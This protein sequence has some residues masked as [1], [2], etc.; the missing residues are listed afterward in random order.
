MLVGGAQYHGACWTQ[1]IGVGYTREV[2]DTL[3]QG[4]THLDLSPETQTQHPNL[5]P[6]PF[7]T[8]LQCHGPYPSTPK[9]KTPE[10]LTKTP[11][12]QVSNITTVAPEAPPSAPATETTALNETEYLAYLASLIPPVTVFVPLNPHI[13]SFK[14]QK[15]PISGL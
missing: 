10:P 2:L 11:R 15:P 1:S 5:S 4:W 7:Q 3:E 12:S 9:L 6:P 13:P 8:D 14:C